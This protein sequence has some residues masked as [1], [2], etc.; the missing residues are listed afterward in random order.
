MFA[1][2]AAAQLA[3]Q[4][5]AYSGRGSFDL[6]PVDLSG[7]ISRYH[8]LLEAAIPSS[9]RLVTDLAAGLPPIQADPTQVQQIILNLV[10]NSADAL[11]ARAGT[12]TIETG[13]EVVGEADQA[14]VY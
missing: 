14:W 1:A 11:G 3:Q 10:L 2:Q 9:I 8:D 13:L 5:L 12:I 4:M 6:Q 7:L